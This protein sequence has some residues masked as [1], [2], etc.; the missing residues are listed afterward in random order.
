AGRFD[1]F[2]EDLDIALALLTSLGV[3]I[4][5]VSIAN[6][7]LMSVTERMSEFGI[8]RANGWS[9]WDLVKL[10]GWESLMLGATGGFLGCVLGW[11]FTVM[12]NSA[13]PAK[14]DLY[15]S[16]SLLLFALCFS[17]ALGVVSGLYPAYW[18]ARMNPMEAIRRN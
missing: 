10:I 14:F 12:I 3:V 7:M 2:A 16:P 8:L 4:A 11:G 15:A 17:A 5:V 13:Y 18:A 6:T 1:K 9:R